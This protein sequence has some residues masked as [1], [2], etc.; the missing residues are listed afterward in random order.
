MQNFIATEYGS[1]TLREVF[2]SAV[3]TSLQNAFEGI[4][5]AVDFQETEALA[6]EFRKS[7]KASMSL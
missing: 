1:S 3:R 2:E 6:A 4:A 7:G 5:L